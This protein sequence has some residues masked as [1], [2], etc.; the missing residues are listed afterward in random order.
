MG[1]VIHARS[2]GVASTATRWY[3]HE[4]DILRDVFFHAIALAALGGCV[5]FLMVYRFPF[6]HLVAR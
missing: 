3:G 2:N 1:K 4:V 5:V 6:V